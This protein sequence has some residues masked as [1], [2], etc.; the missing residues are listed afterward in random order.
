MYESEDAARR[1]AIDIRNN[2]EA[3]LYKIEQAYH[4]MGK[5]LDRSMRSALKADISELK[6]RIVKAKPEKI[7]PIQAGEIRQACDKLEQTAG[8]AGINIPGGL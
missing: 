8:M 4:D 5:K 7:T 6:K 1:E 2:A 3:Y